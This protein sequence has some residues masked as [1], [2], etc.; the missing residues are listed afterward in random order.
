M[1]K[2]ILIPLLIM[3][4]FVYGQVTVT[5]SLHNLREKYNPL[6]SNESSIL[7]MD[8]VKIYTLD[9][10]DTT[11]TFLLKVNK[12]TVDAAS[13]SIGISSLGSGLG[14]SYDVNKNEGEIVMN[15][16]EFKEFYSCI[17]KS[18]VFVNNIK[19]KKDKVN[20]I[21]TCNIGAIT[22]IAEYN[23]KAPNGNEIKFYFKVGNEATYQ[24]SKL[25][26]EK[27]TKTL[28]SIVEKWDSVVTMKP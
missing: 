20:T 2:V 19:Y 14:V 13:V 26:L 7:T 23:P 16:E 3:S 9:K 4:Y 1:K 12:T 18:Y 11:Y 17:S 27:I 22:A 21:A 8:F 6:F 28:K 10:P 5:E 25:E 24:M 15:Y